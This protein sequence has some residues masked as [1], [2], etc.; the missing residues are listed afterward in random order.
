LKKKK[1]TIKDITNVLNISAEAIS[2][3]LHNNSRIS[4]KTKK[5][6]SF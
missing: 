2:K 5:F 4:E 1:A 3:A 6:K